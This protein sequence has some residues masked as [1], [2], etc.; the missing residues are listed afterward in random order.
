MRRYSGT[1]TTT[2]KLADPIIF[3]FLDLLSKDISAAPGRIEPLASTRI[4]NARD[5]TRRIKVRDGDALPDDV[6]F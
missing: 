2:G 4:N 1:I 6:T 3:A 5:L